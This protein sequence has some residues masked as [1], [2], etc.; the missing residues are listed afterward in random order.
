MSRGMATDGA[1]KLQRYRGSRRENGL[2]LI[3]LWVPDPRAP[4][5]QD[6]AE[7]QA[8]TLR[9]AKEETEALEFIATAADWGGDTE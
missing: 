2:K 6:G 8:A 1:D 5:F 9:G 4:G 7:R 3:R